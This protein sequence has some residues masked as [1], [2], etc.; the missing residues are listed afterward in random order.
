ME[1]DFASYDGLKIDFMVDQNVY[2][3]GSLISRILSKLGHSTPS[4]QARK[5][6]T[7]AYTNT[8]RI[9]WKINM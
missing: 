4:L 1:D 6:F 2:I 7:S 8:H 3:R 9:K 5:K